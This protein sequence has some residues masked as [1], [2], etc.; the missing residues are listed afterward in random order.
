MGT[1]KSLILVPL[2]YLKFPESNSLLVLQ[3][4]QIGGTSRCLEQE[5][6]VTSE[7]RAT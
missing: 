2:F 6:Y 4:L 7:T 1:S 5:A 3:E